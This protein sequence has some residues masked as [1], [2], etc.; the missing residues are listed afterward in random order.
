MGTEIVTVPGGGS[1]V[2]VVRVIDGSVKGAA[3][4]FD[5]NGDGQVSAE[6][7]AAQTD[8]S[9]RPFYVTNE[10]GEAQIPEAYEGVRFVAEVTGAYDT[11][12]G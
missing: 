1:G 3:V 7:K 11:A 12:T 10:R 9:G 4:Y 5:L 8:A 6:E 2:P